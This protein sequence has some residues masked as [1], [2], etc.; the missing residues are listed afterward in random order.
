MAAV[1]TSLV[2]RDHAWTGT[3]VPWRLDTEEAPDPDA[4]EEE[5]TRWRLFHYLSG[6]GLSA[7]G[8]SSALALACRRQGRFL[9]FAGALAALWI[10]FWIV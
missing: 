5:R 1:R 10:I 9:V 3:D 2:T 4:P 6:G 8:S 7:C